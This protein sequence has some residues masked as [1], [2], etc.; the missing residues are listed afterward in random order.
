MHV[1]GVTTVAMV[2]MV[3]SHSQP[4]S[5][6]LRAFPACQDQL[7][8]GKKNMFV[9]LV[10]N[11]SAGQ[12]LGSLENGVSWLQRSVCVPVLCELLCWSAEGKAALIEVQGNRVSGEASRSLVGG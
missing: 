11:T 5:T 4:V 3:G 8:L 6:L 10:Y 2:T 1:G 9:L 12:L 7:F